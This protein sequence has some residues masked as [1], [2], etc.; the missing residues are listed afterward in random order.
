MIVFSVFS[1]DFCVMGNKWFLIRYCLLLDRIN[2]DWVLRK[3]FRNLNLFGV[4]VCFFLRCGRFL[5]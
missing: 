5:V 4:I 2:L 3:F 1:L